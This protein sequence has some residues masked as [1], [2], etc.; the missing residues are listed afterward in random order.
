MAEGD[1]LINALIGAAVNV[2]AGP[3][4]PFATVLGGAVAAY[5]QGGSRSDGVRVGALAGLLSLLPLLLVAA[6]VG[7]A[8][9]FALLGGVGVPALVGG[10]GL[11]FVV[12][13]IVFAA[14]Y[15]VAFSAAGGWLGNYVRYDTG[16]FSGT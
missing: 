15:T 13:L 9:L 10:A 16:L 14:V 2:V 5:L 6:V 8:V 1:T 7:N 11:F 3:F 12:L 4:I